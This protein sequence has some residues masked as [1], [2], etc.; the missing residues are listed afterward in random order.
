VFARNYVGV[1]RTALL[2]GV[3]AL[4]LAAPASASV[5][6]GSNLQ[7]TPDPIGPCVALPNTASDCTLANTTL[8]QA[9]RAADGIS[10]PIDGVV[11][12][13]NVKSGGG[14]FSARLRVIR[15]QGI[16]AISQPVSF[17]TPPAQPFETRLPIS[18][19]D[20]V[21]L[22]VIYP[23]SLSPSQALVTATPNNTAFEQW[24][25]PP[26][27]GDMGPPTTNTMTEVLVNAV[28]ELDADHDG[29]GDETQDQCPTDATTQGPC[30]QPPP[31]NNGGN[32]GGTS[33]GGT[34]GTRTGGTGT[35]VIP[36]SS[37]GTIVPPV[38]TAPPPLPTPK[39]TKK[40][41]RCKRAKR[42]H[43]A[44]RCPKRKR[45]ARRR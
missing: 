20:V 40:A 33:N 30:P 16:V 8:P 17:P 42:G 10:S 1:R 12:R 14:T 23:S 7:S 27:Q 18:V 3:I 25:N 44:K 34:G 26:D 45:P 36:V 15:G 11:T 21:G 38:V 13:W 28:I 6:I 37:T 19:G 24:N 35:G 2:A 22:D 4:V 5:T 9:N 41:K 43:R 29:Y 32:N 39:T 31:T